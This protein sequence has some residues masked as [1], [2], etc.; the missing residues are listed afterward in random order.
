MKLIFT[1]SVITASFF[2]VLILANNV[3]STEKGSTRDKTENRVYHTLV[4][5]GDLKKTILL[6]GY[7][8]PDG[9]PERGD[10]WAWDGKKWEFIPG[11][12]PLVRFGGAVVFDSLRKKLVLFGGLNANGPGDGKLLNDT[13]EWNMNNKWK[14]FDVPAP[15]AR[16][17]HAMAYDSHRDKTILFGGTTGFGKTAFEETWEWD[18]RHWEK[19]KTVSGPEGLC[20]FAM[21]YDRWRGKT[22]LFGGQNIKADEDA[23]R[24]DSGETWEWNGASWKKLTDK[25]P[26]PRVQHRMVFDN[27]TGIILLYGGSCKKS[28][29]GGF[30]AMDDMWM[31]DGKQWTEIKY[32]GA[33]PGKRYMHA[34][35]YDEARN[36][37]ILYGG[38]NGEII[39]GDT[40][41]WDGKRWKKV[42]DQ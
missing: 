1:L 28:D 2:S 15:A 17:W 33:S 4:Y 9:T 37:T 27:K 12:G 24:K 14:Q 10:V 38:G 22:I 32:N 19:I 35:A 18:G 26:S 20:D 8:R 23:G 3:S 29:A 34:M 16:A 13:W 7:H 21:V 41:E 36:R 25:G 42:A 31:W 39:F 5:D 11:N 30:T 6:D 40:W